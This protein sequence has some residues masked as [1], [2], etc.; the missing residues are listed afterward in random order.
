MALRNLNGFEEVGE[1]QT[2]VVVI[3]EQREE[4]IF[5]EEE[6][7]ATFRK[8]EEDEQRKNLS[9]ALRRSPSPVSYPYP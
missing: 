5:L 9:V 8:S 4:G 1:G 3:K 2:V 6:E 7:E